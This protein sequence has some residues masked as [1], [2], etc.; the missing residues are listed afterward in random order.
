M[1]GTME[2]RP[3]QVGL[4]GYGS[5]LL[6]SSMEETLGRRYVGERYM[7]RIP[8]WRRT[9]DAVYPNQ[10][11]YFLNRKNEREYPKGIVYLNV[12][13]GQG[14]LNGV[15]YA[16]AVEDLAEFDER[17]KVYDRVDVRT[18]LIDL[19]VD[20]GPVWMYVATPGC[21]LDSTVTTAEAAV[22]RQYVNIV[23][24]GL[25]ELGPEFRADYLLSTEPVPEDRIVN[26]LAD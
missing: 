25:Q 1:P 6:L 23:E 2:L 15:V 26:D 8:G 7:C 21:V 13:P 17:E 10:R 20:G 9:W 12:T 4:F 16:I 19:K 3:G 22:R 14:V 24:A 18:R 11:Y 5:L